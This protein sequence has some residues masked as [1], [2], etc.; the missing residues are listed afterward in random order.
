LL[1]GHPDDWPVGEGPY[2]AAFSGMDLTECNVRTERGLS[3][4]GVQ[5]ELASV[6]RMVHGSVSRAAMASAWNAMRTSRWKG[7]A[8]L[9]FD[10][11]A[12]VAMTINFHRGAARL[13]DRI[14][15]GTAGR[16]GAIE[17]LGHLCNSQPQA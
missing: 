9:F 12:A 13:E 4:A 15:G 17:R 14:N 10:P 16:Q 1:Y 3:P 5:E 6:R 11:L 8:S 7:A 2:P